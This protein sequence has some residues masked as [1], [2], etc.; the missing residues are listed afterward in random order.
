MNKSILREV[1]KIYLIYQFYLR[2]TFFYIPFGIGIGNLSY[3]RES[4]EINYELESTQLLLS[5]KLYDIF[6]YVVE[7]G[8]PFMGKGKAVSNGKNLNTTSLSG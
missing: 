1:N 3:L 2:L 5:Y 8:Y 4:N 6:S 7:Y